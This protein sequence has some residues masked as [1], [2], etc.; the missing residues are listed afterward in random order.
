MPVGAFLPEALPLPLPRRLHRRVDQRIRQKQHLDRIGVAP[1]GPGPAAHTLAIVFQ[2][3][4]LPASV[5]I[6]SAQ[7]AAKSCPREE[8]PAWQVG[9]RPCGDRG[10]FSGPRQRKYLPSWFTARTFL[11]SANIGVSRSI[12]PRRV[13]TRPTAL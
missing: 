8:P 13:P 1:D 10:A 6:V 9:G 4:T 5:M 12:R 7:R 11:P 3:S 2:A